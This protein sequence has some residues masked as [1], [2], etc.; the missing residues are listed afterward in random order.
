M[1][2]HISRKRRPSA[3]ATTIGAESFGRYA[4]VKL[5]EGSHVGYI[6]AKHDQSRECDRVDTAISEGY[7]QKAP[8]NAADG[9]ASWYHSGVVWLVGSFAYSQHKSSSSHLIPVCVTSRFG[10]KLHAIQGQLFPGLL[11]AFM[12]HE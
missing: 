10:C 8:K 11:L 5:I 1:S 12:G 4:D 9:R 7:L 6:P 3:Q 2:R